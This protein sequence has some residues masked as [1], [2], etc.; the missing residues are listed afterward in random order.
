MTARTYF[1]HL[2]GKISPMDLKLQDEADAPDKSPP[3]QH[4]FSIDDIL[5]TTNNSNSNNNGHRGSN[6]PTS[7]ILLRAAARASRMKE[8]FPSFPRPPVCVRPTPVAFHPGSIYSS[9]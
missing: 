3:P 5:S 8:D 6:L 2:G 7:A 9:R 4:K 1:Q